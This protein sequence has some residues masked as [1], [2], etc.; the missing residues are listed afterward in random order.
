MSAAEAKSKASEVAG[1][2][3]AKAEETAGM[4]AAEESQRGC[5]PGTGQGPGDEGLGK[6]HR[7]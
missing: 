1:T 6:G 4:S 2:A 7:C 3:Q 5:R